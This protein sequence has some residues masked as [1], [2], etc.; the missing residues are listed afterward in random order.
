MA[1]LS[2]ANASMNVELSIICE[3]NTTCHV[4]GIN[5]LMKLS[6]IYNI[7]LCRW[8]N[9]TLKNIIVKYLMSFTRMQVSL[10]EDSNMVNMCHI[11]YAMKKEIIDIVLESKVQLRED[12]REDPGI[13]RSRYSHLPFYVM[14]SYYIIWYYTIN[15][16]YCSNMTPHF[17]ITY[18]YMLDKNVKDI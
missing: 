1:S 14:V 16:P 7:L 9:I 3:Y 13:G 10:I 12:A 8:S 15:H 2:T 6:D 5:K 18:I 4:F 17:T 11:H